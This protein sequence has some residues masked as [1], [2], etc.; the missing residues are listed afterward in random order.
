MDR[1]P[2]FR[3]VDVTITYQRKAIESL[4]LRIGFDEEINTSEGGKFLVQT[5]SNLRL[6]TDEGMLLWIKNTSIKEDSENELI[7][8]EYEI[9][10]PS[11]SILDSPGFIENFEG[12]IYGGSKSELCLYLHVEVDGKDVPIRIITD[13][14]T[15][16]T[17]D[18]IYPEPSYQSPIRLAFD[19][20]ESYRDYTY[21]DVRV[22]GL[23][24][25]GQ[26][27]KEQTI[28]WFGAGIGL[29]AG[30]ISSIVLDMLKF[31]DSMNF[32]SF[33]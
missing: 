5:S 24:K 23:S 29:L 1:A 18:L 8:Y 21:S 6:L 4:K 14:Y 19:R 32:K 7:W 17:F 27:T 15:D 13:Y 30:I 12:E 31:L 28:F 16:V 3:F 33:E 22:N 26:T 20:I 9:L 11:S 25:V 2:L 10:E